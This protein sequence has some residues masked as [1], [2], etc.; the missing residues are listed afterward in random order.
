MLASSL[1]KMNFFWKSMVFSSLICSENLCSGLKDERKNEYT[2]VIECTRRI[3]FLK[4]DIWSIT[5]MYVSQSQLITSVPNH[6]SSLWCQVRCAQSKKKKF[7]HASVACLVDDDCFARLV[8]VV[9]HAEISCNSMKQHAMVG[10]HL[11]KLLILS[12]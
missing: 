9:V 6:A 8:H 11:R 5:S 7:L 1:F 2:L 4:L 3:L 10:G 12:A